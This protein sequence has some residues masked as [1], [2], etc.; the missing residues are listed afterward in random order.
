MPVAEIPLEAPL[1]MVF[2]SSHADVT[3]LRVGDIRLRSELLPESLRLPSAGHGRENVGARNSNLE[4]VGLVEVVVSEVGEVEQV[5]L[6]SVPRNVHE[7]MLLSAIKAWC[8][9]PAEK[10]GMAVRYRQVMPITVAR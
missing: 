6:I 2:D 3:P 8:F 7:S 4:Q 10:D 9:D 1:F 5:K